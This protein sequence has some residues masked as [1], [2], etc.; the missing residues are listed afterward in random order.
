MVGLPGFGFLR[1]LIERRSLLYQMVRRDFERRYV[2][3]MGGWLWGLLQPLILLLS[4]TFVFHWCMQM[5]VPPGQG[6]RNYTVFLFTGYLPWMLFNE[7]VLRSSMSLLENANLITKTVFPSEIIPVSVFLS[8][9]INHA[10]TFLIAVAACIYFD[11]GVSLFTWMLP[12]YVVLLGLFAIGI[13]WMVAAFQVYLRD[14]AQV[15]TV[16]LTFWFWITPIFI[17][18][19]RVPE[20]FRFLL[21]FNPLS[22]L[23]RAYRD[24]M[25]TSRTPDW[26]ELAL[27][28]LWAATAFL[29]GGLIFKQLKK[30]FADVL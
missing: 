15:V 17:D 24:R 11:G 25:L 3:S 9:L 16:L 14:T 26:G 6:T 19:E 4:W 21:V 29:A 28:T 22:F 20:R 27:L 10:L 12:I 1:N 13:S 23:V 7:T 8:S 2:G 30:G 5:E 18:L